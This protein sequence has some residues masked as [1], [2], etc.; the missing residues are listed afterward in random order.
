MSAA[1][2]QWALRRCGHDTHSLLPMGSEVVW[3]RHAQHGDEDAV[4]GYTLTG[5]GSSGTQPPPRHRLLSMQECFELMVGVLELNR[6][7]SRPANCG[8]RL[9]AWGI[10][11]FGRQHAKSPEEDSVAEVGQARGCR[12]RQQKDSVPTWVGEGETT[13][14]PKGLPFFT[15]GTRVKNGHV[16]CCCV[17]VYRNILA[18]SSHPAVIADY[19]M[20]LCVLLQWGPLQELCGVSM[21]RYIV[22]STLSRSGYLVMRCAHKRRAEGKG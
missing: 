15:G 16:C 6:G 4:P 11:D 19:T 2:F 9:A 7:A 3:P 1:C 8:C 20:R 21:E 13:A 17:T 12:A 18:P 5:G 22:Y 10:L 14:V